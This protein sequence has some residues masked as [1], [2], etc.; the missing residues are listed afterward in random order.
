MS[1]ISGTIVQKFHKIANFLDITSD[2]KDLPRFVTKKWV[3]VSD[4]SEGNYKVN[5]DIRIKTS[6]LHGGTFR[7]VSRSFRISKQTVFAIAANAIFA[8]AAF[9]LMNLKM[10]GL[11]SKQSVLPQ[12]IL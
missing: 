7:L 4:Q 10:A 1:T 2:D 8:D 9:F 5:K 11:K 12:T 6:M 3:E